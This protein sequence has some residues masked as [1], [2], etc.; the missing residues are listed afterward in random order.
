M[1]ENIFVV[2]SS[3]P[4]KIGK[5]IRVFTGEE[6]NHVSIALDPQL[7][8]MYSF[9]RRYY[10][11]PFY[12]GFVKESLSRYHLNG[13]SA[14]VRICKIPVT[15]EQH[16]SLSIRM[17]KMM[18]KKEL[19]LYN[20][21]SALGTVVKKPVRTKAAYTCVEFCVMILSKIGMD[22]DPNKFYTI[23]ELEESLRPYTVYLGPMP[24][25]T[26]TDTDFYAKKPVPHPTA[27]TIRDIAKLVPRIKAQK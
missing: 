7:T 12:G 9:A 19:Y 1:P 10:K 21:I 20:H 4:Y 11:T 3:T 24:E 6:F 23:T 5:A 26:S 27:R 16:R 17:S 8:Q 22:V 15:E 2:F 18:R 25:S 14:Y 13:K